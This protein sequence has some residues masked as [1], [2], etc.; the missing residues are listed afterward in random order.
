LADCTYDLTLAK[1][2]NF[3]V[4][5]NKTINSNDYSSPATMVDC[6]KYYLAFLRQIQRIIDQGK[7]RSQVQQES[8]AGKI[9]QSLVYKNFLRSKLECKRHTPFS[10]RYAWNVNG[11]TFYLRYPS[12]ITAKK[13]REWLKRKVK[14]IN[15]KDSKE[16]DRIQAFIDL[17]LERGFHISID[18]HDNPKNYGIN[19]EEVQQSS[20]ESKEGRTFVNRL[21]NAVAQQKVAN[22]SS[23]RPSIKKLGRKATESMILQIFSDLSEGDYSATQIAAKYGISKPTFSR[24]AGSR[25][26]EQTGDKRNIKIPDLWRNTAKILAKTPEFMETALSSGVAGKLEEILGLIES[27]KDQNNGR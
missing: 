4:P 8:Y 20:I 16:Q 5:A 9:L 19:V 12:H 24:F 15:P 21:A 3:P 1:F 27:K 11:N 2:S 10:V 22:I 25:W 23:L 6:R 18:N 26:F 17:N 13:F 7:I 14:E